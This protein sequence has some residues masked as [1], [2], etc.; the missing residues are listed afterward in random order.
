MLPD[1][2]DDT[3]R[4]P[5]AAQE[6]FDPYRIVSPPLSVTSRREVAGCPNQ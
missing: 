6:R 4:L 1:L 3:A 5:R 2:L